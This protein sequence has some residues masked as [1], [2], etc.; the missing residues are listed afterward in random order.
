MATR[1]QGANR[2]LRCAECGERIVPG[3]APGVF[4]HTTRVVAAC[5][6]DAD[7][8]AIPDR[9]GLGEHRDPAQEDDHPA[10]PSLPPS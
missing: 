8:T 6:L 10:E 3:R 9:Q 7:H 1:R 2:V 5:D 4:V